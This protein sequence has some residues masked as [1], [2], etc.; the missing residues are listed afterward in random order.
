LTLFRITFLTAASAGTALTA[1]FSA[2]L[3]A[4]AQAPAGYPA[5]YGKIVDAAKKEGKLVIYSATDTKAVEPMIKDFKTMYPDVQVEYN[6]MNSTEVY[7]RY[8]SET[9]AGGN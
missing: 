1:S 6:D 9:A 5:D 4:Y 3:T 8:I 7:N 2:P